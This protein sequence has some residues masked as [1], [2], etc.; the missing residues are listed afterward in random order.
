MKCGISVVHRGP[1]LTNNHYLTLR[2]PQLSQL[3]LTSLCPAPETLFRKS[4][5]LQFSNLS[6]PPPLKEKKPSLTLSLGT[7]GL[8]VTSEP[9]PMTERRPAWKDRIA[10]RSP[11]QAAATLDVA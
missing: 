2:C 11:I 7:S 6:T 4:L 5:R 10:Q 9:P 8:K 3:A 1:R